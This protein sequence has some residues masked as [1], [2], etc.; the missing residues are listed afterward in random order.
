MSE[1]DAG[2]RKE[3]E[4]IHIAF[5]TAPHFPS[6]FGKALDALNDCMADV[7]EANYARDAR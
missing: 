6:R 7:A 1:L 3:G 2:A 5:A 4:Q